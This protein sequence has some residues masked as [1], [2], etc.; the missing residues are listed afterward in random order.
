MTTAGARV[1][2][3]WPVPAAIAAA[4][5]VAL[6]AQAWAGRGMLGHGALAAGGPRDAALLGFLA[7]WVLMLAAMMLPSSLP[8]VRLFTA[9]SASQPRAG[10]AQALF[11]GG[12]AAVWLA[13]GTAAFAADVVVHQLVAGQ[14]WVAARPWLLTAGLLAGAGGFQFTKLKDRC[15]D[16]CRH[17]AAFL[18]PRYRHGAQAAYRLGRAHGLSCL[19]CCWALMLLL[20]GAGLADLRWMAA[21]GALMTYEKVGRHGRGAA[22]VAG[23]GLLAAGLLVVVF[24]PALAQP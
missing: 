1:R 15:L 21:L 13:F 5:V 3:P 23:V 10:A 16:R 4:W 17:P 2:V 19:G 6:A 8:M 18:L 14:P 9:T 11:L 7:G 22:R 20:F 24:R 12:Y